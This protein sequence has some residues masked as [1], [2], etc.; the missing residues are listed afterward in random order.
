MRPARPR[1]RDTR[2]LEAGRGPREAGFTL[3]E[4]LVAFVIL[5]LVM[6][7]LQRGVVGSV[8]A[9]VRAR[10]RLEAGLVARTLLSSATI[11]QTGQA[12]SGRM[13]GHDW[14]VRFEDVG[15]AAGA[16]GRT[17]D[18]VFQPRR[19]IVDVRLSGSRSGVLTVE[20]IQPIRAAAGTP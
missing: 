19:M 13:N 17:G 6:T 1:P 18:Q 3:I 12:A 5:A 7:V 10:D 15:L 11:V 9:S 2:A 20:Q 14:R 16:V 8:N 4:A